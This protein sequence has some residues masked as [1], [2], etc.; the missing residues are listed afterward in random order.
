[1]PT[2][3]IYLS[4]EFYEMVKSCPSKIIKAAL[5]QYFQ[6]EGEKQKQEKDP[7]ANK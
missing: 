3:T 5:E 6:N 7:M 4:A 2:I 1:M